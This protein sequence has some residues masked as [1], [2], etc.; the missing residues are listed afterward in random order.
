MP[1]HVQHHEIT[2]YLWSNRH[3][4]DTQNILYLKDHQNSL[5]Y[6]VFAV[7]VQKEFQRVE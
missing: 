7:G 4:E 1:K 6:D 5:K 3:Y 2:A